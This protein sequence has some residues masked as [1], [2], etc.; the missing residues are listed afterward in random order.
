MGLYACAST[1]THTRVLPGPQGELEMWEKAEQSLT[2]AL[3]AMGRPWTI[4]E[5]GGCALEGVCLGGGVRG[6]GASG[7]RPIGRH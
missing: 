4:N 6:G 7:V 3:N 2:D 5:G 1:Y